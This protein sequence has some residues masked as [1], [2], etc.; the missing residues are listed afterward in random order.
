MNGIN[1]NFKD[2]FDELKSNFE[3]GNIIEQLKVDIHR[4]YIYFYMDNIPNVNKRL[5]RVKN[6]DELILFL[7]LL[8]NYYNTKLY[9]I[10][11]ICNQCIF[12]LIYKHILNITEKMY[13]ESFLLDCDTSEKTIKIHYSI[14]SIFINIF[15]KFELVYINSDTFEKKHIYYV[16]YNL[17]FFFE[18]HKT[19]KKLIIPKNI[20][21][22][23]LMIK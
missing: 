22:H 18:Y 19:S 5:C 9:F 16:I 4:L 8:D 11:Y 14:N 2:F 23:Y 13:E 1:I 6:F 7:Y 3:N 21:L 12:H 15:G 20:Y 17:S 10:A